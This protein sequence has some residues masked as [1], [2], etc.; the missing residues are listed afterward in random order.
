MAT[1]RT[2][3][4]RLLP[5]F[6]RMI[7]LTLVTIQQLTAAVVAAIAI[8]KNHQHHNNNNKIIPPLPPLSVPVWSLAC[9]SIPSTSSSTIPIKTTTTTIEEPN[10][11]Q[12]HLLPSHSMN[13]VTFCTGLSVAPP[14]LYAVSLYYDTLTKDSFLYHGRGILQLLRPCH[15]RLVPILGQ[16]SGYRTNSTMTSKAEQCARL[17]YPWHAY[18]DDQLL[19]D[20]ALYLVLQLVDTVPAGD[21]VL[22]ICQVT[23]TLVWHAEE[24]RIVVSSQQQQQQQQQQPSNS[25][26]N[27]NTIVSAAAATTAATT[28]PL[29]LLDSSNTLYTGQLREEGIL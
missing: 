27:D 14:K 12:L 21:H 8:A 24:Q 3:R 23:D 25:N 13:I 29:L 17:G 1:T 5:S 15:K 20:C 2:D 11:Q 26:I 7:I 16:Q 19:A 22:T 9:Q 4:W 10:Q 18:A 28:A 6:G